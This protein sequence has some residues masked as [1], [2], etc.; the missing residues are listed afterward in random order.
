MGSQKT[1]TISFF[2]SYFVAS[3]MSHFLPSLTSYYMHACNEGR[4]GHRKQRW[5]AA[6]V[7]KTKKINPK[8]T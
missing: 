6:Q 3:L 7:K 5:A 8:Q 4:R 1:R 2:I